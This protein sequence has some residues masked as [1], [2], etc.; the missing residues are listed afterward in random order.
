MLAK[1][2]FIYSGPH[3]K[4][5]QRAFGYY[6]NKV[7]IAI[8][9]FGE[10]NKVIAVT[11]RRRRFVGM[12]RGNIDLTP[13]DGFDA[14]FAAFEVKVKGAIEVAVVGNGTGWK[15]KVFGLGA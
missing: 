1:N 10:Q 12:V 9:V 4:P 6:F 14:Y 8:E 7:V 15:A 13:N 11:S 3:I 5:V 2:V